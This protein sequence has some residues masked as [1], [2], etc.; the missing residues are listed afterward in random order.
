MYYV[1]NGI[2]HIDFRNGQWQI[3][4]D[5]AQ[6]FFLEETANSI[7]DCVRRDGLQ[8]SVKVLTDFSCGQPGSVRVIPISG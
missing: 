2:T 5:F 3:S 1:S 7:R 4:D 8:M 6:I